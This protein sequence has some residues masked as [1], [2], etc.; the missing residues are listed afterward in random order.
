[1]QHMKI[2]GRFLKT[3]LT[4]ALALSAAHVAAQEWPSRPLRL[5]VPFPPGG[6]SDIVARLIAQP[7]GEKLKQTVLV[8]NRPGGGTTIGARAVITANDGAHTLFVANSAPI[9]IALA[10]RSPVLRRCRISR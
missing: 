2:L 10:M 8:D 7:L 1:M 9:S 6:T 5:I 3:T 4:A